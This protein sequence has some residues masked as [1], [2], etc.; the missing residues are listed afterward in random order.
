MIDFNIAKKQ[1]NETE[2]II[3]NDFYNVFAP[4]LLIV[5]SITDN[6]F[7][8]IL[9][10]ISLLCLFKFPYPIEYNNLAYALIGIIGCTIITMFF[11]EP[12]KNTKSEKDF[13]EDGT[14]TVIENLRDIYYNIYLEFWES[15]KLLPAENEKQ[16]ETY[17]I[18][19]K[20]LD[21]ILNLDFHQILKEQTNINIIREQMGNYKN[22]VQQLSTLSDEVFFIIDKI[23]KSLLIYKYFFN[24]YLIKE[25]IDNLKHL[26]N[27]E[28]S[29]T[30]DYE[31]RLEE[32]RIL[33]GNV[34]YILEDLHKDIYFKTIFHTNKF[35][36]F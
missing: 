20:N 10:L 5:K 8:F 21:E 33:C 28:P 16:V 32:L 30:T 12:I 31:K 35:L 19:I 2:D 29:K 11:V 13:Y 7:V 26:A 6:F 22:L 1:E 25:K 4:I 24:L 17:A 34:K 36:Y 14:E 23:P 9:L 3:C 15:Y 27:E 18:M